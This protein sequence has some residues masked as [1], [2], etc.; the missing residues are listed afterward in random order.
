MWTVSHNSFQ[1]SPKHL[2][3][4]TGLYV[5]S[6]LPTCLTVSFSTCPLSQQA[7]ATPSLSMP[8]VLSKLIPAPGPLHVLLLFLESS[9]HGSL[10]GGFLSSAQM[11][12]PQRCSLTI[13][14]PIAVPA[15]GYHVCFVSVI[16]L[17]TK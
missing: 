7:P 11:L 6:P 2:F 16:A 17:I 4:S 13:I 3:W 12:P 8:R 5:F 14:P 9:A 10:H 1:N 15:N